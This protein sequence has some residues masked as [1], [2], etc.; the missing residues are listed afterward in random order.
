MPGPITHL[1]AAYYYNV[2]HKKRYNS[3]L[4]LGSISPDCVNINGQAPKEVRWPAHLRCEDLDEWLA[5]ARRF[6]I[7]NKST[8]D[9][10]F[11]K[12]YILHILSDIVWDKDFNLPLYKILLKDNVSKENL[13]QER[14][15]ELYGYEQTQLKEDWFKNEVL[16]KLLIA[17]PQ[18]IGVLTEENIGVWQK[19]VVRLELSQGKPPK[20]IN[21]K[22]M[23]QFFCKVVMLSDEILK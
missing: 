12:G 23:K 21:Y 3:A 20:F 10:S 19:K 5:N 15:N 2:S 16:P 8:A 14:W 17:K 1:Q 4:Y 7:D 22:L 13:K 11:L 18:Q 9:E 6:Y